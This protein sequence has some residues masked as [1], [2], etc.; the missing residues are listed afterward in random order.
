M[1]KS[2]VDVVSHVLWECFTL[3]AWRKIYC[4]SK[5]AVHNVYSCAT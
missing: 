1:R 2:G 4:F 3:F 5:S